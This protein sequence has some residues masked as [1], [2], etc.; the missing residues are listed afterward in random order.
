M[1]AACIRV[2]LIKLKRSPIWIAFAAM[3]LLGTLIGCA[4]YLQNLGVITPGWYN[5][6]TQETLFLCYFFMPALAGAAC[7][8]L[9]RLEHTGSNWNE[10]MAAP[11]RPWCI[12][13]AKLSVGG[14]CMLA[15]FAA[16]AVLFVGS[17]L[18]LGV[19]GALPTGRIAAYLVLGWVGS[20]VIV[21]VQLVVSLLVR[22]FAAPVGIAVGGG[23]L[24]LVATMGG[25]G[26]LFPYS[27]MQNGMA[28]NTLAVLDA[29]T[30]TQ[31]LGASAVYV[32]VAVAFASIWLARRDV[33]A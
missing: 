13:V 8:F 21:A 4:N 12:V 31:L 29:G 15:A 30:V 7:S 25:I 32:A 26:N 3:P 19:P 5:L 11:V 18:A 23:V 1:L 27:I 10:L 22:N 2:E 24:G 20:F 28:S 33:H 9:W 16:V 6:W 14:L 17:G